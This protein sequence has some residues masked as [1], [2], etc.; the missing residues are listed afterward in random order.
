MGLSKKKKSWKSYR[1]IISRYNFA[2][3]PSYFSSG[4]LEGE[5]GGGFLCKWFVEGEL[6]GAACKGRI[7]DSRDAGSAGAPNSAS[8]PQRE[9]WSMSG[10]APPKVGDWAFVAWIH[11][12]LAASIP[13]H[14]RICLR[15]AL[16]SKV[17]LL[18][19]RVG[20][21]NLH[22]IYTCNHFEPFPPTVPT[23]YQTPSLTSVQPQR[24]LSTLNTLS[25]FCSMG[26]C[27]LTSLCTEQSLPICFECLLLL[28]IDVS[29]LMSPP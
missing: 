25:S 19:G 1:C 4:S 2:Y 11:K 8:W 13:H 9:L 18:K 16:Q 21:S 12:F 24:F 20:H 3:T 26:F 28:F 5:P 27:T 14:W 7:G 22:Y 6:S 29:A 23:S 10:T 15:A 17:T